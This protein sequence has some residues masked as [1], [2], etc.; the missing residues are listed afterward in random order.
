MEYSTK[1]VSNPVDYICVYTR[2][3]TKKQSDDK[4]HGLSYQKDLCKG[5]IDKFYSLS[6]D[7]SYREDVGSSYKSK[8]ILREM[9]ELI[10]KLKP[11]TLIVVSEVSR[12]GRNYSMVENVLKS[13]QKKKSFVI[14][15]S[16]NLVYGLSKLKNGQFIHKVN[17]SEKESDVLS[18]RVKNTHEYIKRN[19][20]Y[21][22]KP[23][24]GY[25]VTKNSRNL[26]VLK[27]KPEDFEL[28]DRIVNL[29][30]DCYTYAEIANIMNTKKIFYKGKLWT[31]AKIKVILKKFYPEHML[32]SLSPNTKQNINVIDEDLEYTI[33]D[34]VSM[35]CIESTYEPTAYPETQTKT[36]NTIFEK[37]TVQI[38]N[39]KYKKRIVLL[40]TKYVP[41]TKELNISN[42][43]D[44]L[45]LTYNKTPC[46]KLR[47]G[48]IIIKN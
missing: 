7:I 28:I 39:D 6:N 44:V 47:S 36:K 13:I 1:L 40:D 37:L 26:P 17:D 42:N 14:S 33:D 15:I 27:E 43:K 4:K 24:F 12:L 19:G 45:P 8:S 10:R 25:F 46:I 16:E 22:G 18:M 9:C 41:D 5:Y 11:N 38:T 30:T 32:L 35:N 34:D 48:K 3:S 23:P 20:G 2:V 31:S 21:I 29:T